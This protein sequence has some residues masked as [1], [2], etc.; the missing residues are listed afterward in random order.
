[1]KRLTNM[2]PSTCGRDHINLKNSTHLASVNRIFCRFLHGPIDI[3]STGIPS[4]ACSLVS[5]SDT[6]WNRL[7]NTTTN[8][9]T[10][11]EFFGGDALDPAESR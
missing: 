4:F 7:T 3:V 9:R 8:R 6:G 11:D 2:V 5:C 10:G 1:M